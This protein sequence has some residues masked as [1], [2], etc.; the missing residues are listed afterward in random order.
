LENNKIKQTAGKTA[1]ENA[2]KKRQ[3]VFFGYIVLLLTVIF[4]VTGC[5][6]GTGG[7]GDDTFV[8]VTNITDL[9]QVAL[10]DVEL[11]LGG[12]VV[13]E[14]A[15]NQTITWSGNGVI[16]GK[17]KAASTGNYTVTATVANGLSAGNPYTKSFTITVYDGSAS[18]ITAI[19]GDWT[20]P[21]TGW[22]PATSTDTMTITGS[23]FVMKNDSI[24]NRVYCSG[25]IMS[26]TDANYIVQINAILNNEGQLRPFFWYEEGT[27]TFTEGATTMTVTSNESSPS[28]GTWTKKSS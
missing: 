8:A 22:F 10:K 4:T 27:H 3:G 13:P 15:N 26:L 18:V 9:P 5:D 23:A 2:M 19:Q 21:S 28:W 11:E 1:K 25:I 14:N 6:N 7:G 20:K 24:G 16:D 12:V 17:F